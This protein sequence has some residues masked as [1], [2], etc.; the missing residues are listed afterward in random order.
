M[1]HSQNQ[2]CYTDWQKNEESRRNNSHIISFMS[3][4]QH[5]VLTTKVWQHKHSPA[6][7]DHFPSVSPLK[8]RDSSH[9][10]VLPLELLSS[11]G[12]SSCHQPW[13]CFYL[14][15]L[16][17]QLSPEPPDMKPAKFCCGP[18]LPASKHLDHIHLQTSLTFCGSGALS[19]I[20]YGIAYCKIKTSK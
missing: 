6:L 11:S 14:G 19:V 9:S 15:A 5:G 12:S 7:T 2:T 4:T 16:T 17:T 8:R 1:L 3:N 13:L 18:H 20:Y 10:L